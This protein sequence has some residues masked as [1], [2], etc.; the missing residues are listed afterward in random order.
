LDSG[1]DM[2]NPTTLD[3][4]RLGRVKRLPTKIAFEGYALEALL[5]GNP[6]VKLFYF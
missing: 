1:R 4:V 2:K 6:K 5:T 3:R